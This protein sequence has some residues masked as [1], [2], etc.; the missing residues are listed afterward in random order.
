LSQRLDA[1][2]EV[3]DFMCVDNDAMVAAEIT[4]DLATT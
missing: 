3:D 4:G 1:K 2:V